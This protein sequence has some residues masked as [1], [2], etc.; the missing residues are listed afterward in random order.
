LLRPGPNETISGIVEFSW[1]P[2]GP[3]P[4]G[5]VYEVVWWEPNADPATARAIAEAISDTTLRASLG[6][7]FDRPLLIYW[8]VL[9]VRPSPYQR[10][11]QPTDSEARLLSVCR[12]ECSMQSRTVTDPV[13]G[14]QKTVFEERCS[15]SC[16]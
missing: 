12:R 9:V 4:P 3:L 11:T 15:Q 2:G 14:D 6:V 10:L 1:Q 5:A 7:V 16:P 13:T 8:T